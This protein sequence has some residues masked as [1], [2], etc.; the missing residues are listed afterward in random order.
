ML[1][2]IARNV[3]IAYAEAWWNVRNEWVE[4]PSRN[5]PVMTVPWPTI[6][7]VRRPCER[8]LMDPVRDANPFF[9]VMEFVWMMSGSND[10][11][12]VAQFNKQMMEYAGPE[13][14]NKGAYGWRWRKHFGV[15]QIAD[16]ITQLRRDPTTRQAVLAMWDPF[17]DNSRI[18]NKDRPCNT[19]IYLRIVDEALTMTVC[20]R[21]NDMVWGMLGANAVHMTLLHELIASAVDLEPKNYRVFTNNL[22][23]YKDVPR[24]EEMRKTVQAYNYYDTICPYPLLVKN[25]SWWDLLVDCEAMVEGRQVFRT[26][27]M[28]RVAH[29]MKMSYLDRPKRDWW[30]NRIAADD[31]RL[32]V[33]QWIDRRDKKQV[34]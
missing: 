20:N 21:S 14:V 32:A 6:L 15:D 28:N 7:T 9:H 3:P 4:E 18:L 11:R 23:V 26:E 16:V 5:G 13:G 34:A 25:E 27:W 19:H 8:V 10:Q 12:W 24:F 31:W 2:I 17:S 1:E 33:E 30:V 29:P 22:H